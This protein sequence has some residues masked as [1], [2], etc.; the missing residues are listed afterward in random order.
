[1]SRPNPRRLVVALAM[2]LLT[3]TATA[4]PVTLEV[5]HAFGFQRET[6]EEIARRFKAEHPDVTVRLRS[7]AESYEELL[8]SNLRDAVAGT[9]PDVAFHG[10]NRVSVLSERGLA[11][12]LDDFVAAE[13]DWAALG[14]APRALA[15]AE[16]AG[17]PYGL[18]FAISTPIVFLNGDLVRRAGGDPAA[19]PGH[20]PGILQLVERIQGLGGGVAGGWLDWTSGSNWEFVALVESQGGRMM[21]AGEKAIAFDGHEG[22][23][24]LRILRR[25]G[26]LGQ[27]AMSA[28]QAMQAFTAGK[29]G[30]YIGSSA[31][32]QR[33]T[34]EIAGR[35]PLLTGSFPRTADGRLPA[36]GN[37]G[38]M[39]TKNPKEQ[40][41]AWAY[42]KFATGPVGQTIMVERTGYVPGNITVA[43]DPKLLKP[44]Y[45]ANP[46]LMT[47]VRQLP[48][49]SAFF[50]FPGENSIKLGALIRDHLGTVVNL[51]ATPD[52]AMAA[53]VRDAGRLLP[54]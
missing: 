42:L 51:Q 25:F 30:L 7:V 3:G 50:A 1:M 2:G 45:D 31:R 41:A 52:A 19:P 39:L 38:L 54:R 44:F 8:Q 28:D 12:P 6:H 35:F 4:E 20:W 53:M 32:T 14:Y 5:A 10:F 17:K 18:P 11:V 46:N 24:A 13:P 23:E 29:L 49:M 33:L 21:T 40:R 48:V 43:E 16:V 26:E 22:R 27:V 37:A 47:S 34:R 15:L 9:V 36:G